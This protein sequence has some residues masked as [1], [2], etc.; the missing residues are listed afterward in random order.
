MSSERFQGRGRWPVVGGWCGGRS[1]A[2]S[3][4]ARV[5]LDAGELREGVEV[6][7][8]REQDE[9]VLQ[10]EG[11]DPHVVGGYGSALLAELPEDVGVVMG[12]LVVCVEDADA[13]LEKKPAQDGLVV[14]ALDRK[15]TRL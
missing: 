7:V 15:S 13:R 12:G 4:P 1:G 14:G 9:G 11:G 6:R 8:A 3:Q 5:C 10:G 2:V